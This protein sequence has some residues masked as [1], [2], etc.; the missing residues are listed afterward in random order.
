MSILPEQRKAHLLSRVAEYGKL[1]KKSQFGGYSLMVDEV[2]FAITT[3]N[4]FYLKGSGFVET[5][6]KANNMDA[7]VY[8]KK[9]IP[10]TLRYYRITQ[11]IWRNS[12]KLNQ[13]IDFAYHYS[14]QEFLGQQKQ[15]R[16]I[17]D[18]PNLGI[19]LEKKLNQVGINRIEELRTIGAKACYLK[20][21]AQP[22]QGNSDLLLALAGAIVGCHRSV[23]PSQLKMELLNWYKELSVKSY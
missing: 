20:L 9:G 6:Y 11:A 2:I 21:I 22:K 16:R 3:D 8:L 23:L 13:Y 15:P 1:S 18:L 19:A 5:L 12:A 10:I 14:T 7:Y 4:E 17:K